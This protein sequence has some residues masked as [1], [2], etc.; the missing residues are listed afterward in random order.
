MVDQGPAP[1]YKAYKTFFYIERNLE[2][3]DS[4]V[5]DKVDMEAPL[6]DVFNM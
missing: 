6:A 3:P 2:D 5:E 4:E 1:A